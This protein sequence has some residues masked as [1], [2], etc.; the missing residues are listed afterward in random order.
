MLE[1][2]RNFASEI[3]SIFHKSILQIA[4]NISLMAL[5]LCGKKSDQSLHSLSTSLI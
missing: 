3:S 1:E 2:Y 4:E 5:E